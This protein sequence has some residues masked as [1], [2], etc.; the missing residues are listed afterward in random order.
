MADHPGRQAV[1]EHMG[2]PPAGPDDSGANEQLSDNVA[3]GSWASQSLPGSIQTQ[4][5]T[6]GD[7]FASVQPEVEGHGFANVGWQGKV[8]PLLPFAPHE[9]FTRAPGN[10]PHF[11][12]DHFTGA[13][14]EAG[15]EEHDGAVPPTRWRGHVASSEDLFHVRRGQVGGHGGQ[16]PFPEPRYPTGEVKGHLSM[17]VEEPQQAPEGAGD[18]PH[19]HA[20]PIMRLFQQ[21]GVD[22]LGAPIAWQMGIGKPRQP[23]DGSPNQGRVYVDGLLGQAAF[24][25]Q[26]ILVPGKDP[27]SIEVLKGIQGSGPGTIWAK[28]DEEPEKDAPGMTPP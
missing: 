20:G 27:S 2:R 3:H 28:E 9:D 7:A 6:P 4:E 22:C 1:A 11:Q 15:K 14:A 8:I 13:Q 5:H 25:D 21:E 18:Q 17:K 23:R 24:I 26:E 12:S 19:A 16:F 10:V